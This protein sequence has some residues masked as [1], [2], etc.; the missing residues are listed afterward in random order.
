MLIHGTIPRALALSVTIFLMMTCQALGADAT[1]KKVVVIGPSWENFTNKD[2]TGLYH[3]L[4]RAAYAP[5]G[6]E[7]KRIYAPSER[8]Y[9][10][11][12]RGRADF[13]TCNDLPVPQLVPAS[14]PMYENDFHAFFR[15]SNVPDWKGAK[16]LVGREVVWRKGYYTPENFPDGIRH[17]ELVSGASCLGVVILGRADFYIDDIALIRMSLKENKMPFNMDDFA[18]RPV[19]KRAYYPMFAKTRLGEKAMKIYNDAMDVLYRS[20]EMKKIFD[21]WNFEVP[22]FYTHQL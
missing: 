8:A 21:K 22:T 2:G 13:M 5:L 17:R 14:R 6:I 11:V 9:E 4:L 12:R 16:S 20:G 10:M 1:P 15:K 7:V 19:G 18:I 3:E